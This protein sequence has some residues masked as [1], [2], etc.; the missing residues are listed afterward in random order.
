VGA[1]AELARHWSAAYELP[2]ALAASVD[3]AAAAEAAGGFAEAHEHLERAIELWDQVADADRP[4]S[5]DRLGLVERA[6]EDGHLAGDHHRAAALAQSALNALDPAGDPVRRGLLHERL[7][8][9]LAA[10]GH[11]EDALAAYAEAVRL[12]T[13]ETSPERARVLAAEARALMLS[14][15][16]RESRQRAT[17]AVSIAR[18]AGARLEEGQA[19]GTLG[20]DLALLG[21][22]EVGVSYLREAL[23][24]AEEVGDLHGV[25]LAYRH[26]AVVLSGPLSRLDEALTVAR[27]GLQRVQQL[28]LDRHYGVSLQALAADTLFRLGRWEEAD[29]LLAAALDHDPV[30]AAAIDLYLARAKLSVGR[31]RFEA[32]EEDLRTITELSTLVL[33][34]QFN[35]PRSTLRAGLALWQGRLD[36]AREAVAQGLAELADTDE[37]WLLGPVLWHGVRTE[38]EAAA[39]ARASRRP[40]G[41]DEAATAGV[42]VLARA[43]LLGLAAAGA[44]AG[45]LADLL[46]AYMTMCEGEASRI[47]GAEDPE[48]WAAAAEAWDRLG[49]PYPA[50]YCRWRRADA[51]LA[52]GDRSS[53]PEALVRRAHG[54]AMALGARPLQ[55]SIEDLARRA[56]IDLTEPAAD[57][58]ADSAADGPASRATAAGLTRREQQVLALLAT[59]RTNRE[60][61]EAL[62]I[63]EKTASVHVSNILTKLGVRS[64][65]EAAGVAQRWGLGAANV[66]G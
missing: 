45:A 23:A 58:A 43:R 31:G 6:A 24:L 33:D 22:P 37:V 60:L 17:E 64:R 12:V 53:E 35:V 47:D 65:V 61:A 3:A 46:G 18:R 28:R 4:P 39:Q 49:Q 1:W 63:S 5:L 2:S 13:E 32:A 11:S 55:S 51:L 21:E 34:P 50:A 29:V 59:G 20:F 19:L 40:D 44:G 9:Y 36:D 14:A 27:D 16:Y 8:C 15:R 25:A 56:R 62:F 48:P 52:R 42:A 41:A 26:L 7:G 38:A 30:G 10:A 57:S 54:V 66:S